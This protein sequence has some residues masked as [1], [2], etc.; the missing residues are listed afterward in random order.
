M[1]TGTF[2]IDDLSRIAAE[3]IGVDGLVL[4]GGMSASSVPGWDSLNHTLIIMEIGNSLGI[5]IGADE[6]GGA[7]DFAAL[8]VLVNSR[9]PSGQRL[10]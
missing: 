1:I 5:E 9:L 6:T 8:V 3:V 10:S 2:T 7:K 4:A